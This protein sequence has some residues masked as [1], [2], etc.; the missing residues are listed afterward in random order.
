MMEPALVT[1]IFAAP[2]AWMPDAPT[3]PTSILAEFVIAR[4]GGVA[5]ELGVGIESAWMAVA[6]SPQ[7]VMLPAA[8]FVSVMPAP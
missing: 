1:E 6:L 3:P 2:S 7:V 8:E 4:V 5:G